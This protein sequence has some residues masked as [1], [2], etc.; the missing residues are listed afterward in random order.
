MTRSIRIFVLPT[1]LIAF[2]AVGLA[3]KHNITSAQIKAEIQDKIY[4]AHIFQH[5]NVQVAY[6][7]GIAT[8][9]GSVDSIGVKMDAERAAR[10]VDEVNQVVNNITVNLGDTSVRSVL[11]QARKSIILY[12]F[13]T[14]YDHIVLRYQTGDLT[15]DGQVTDPFKKSD[16]GNFLSHIPG[17]AELT[18]DLQVLPVS[19]Y[20]N[21]LRLVIARAIYDD[22]YFIN[23]RNQPLPPIHIIVDN[24]NVTLYGVVNS[25]MDKQKAGNDARLAATFFSFKNDL[26]VEHE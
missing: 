23:Y 13:Y 1:I 11:N 16:I 18:N 8:L 21:E 24:G 15:V 14:I 5:G 12:P 7:N 19:Q 10:K 25:P 4:H 17:V 2:A 3:Q 22:P 20:D 6:A 9:T 26:R